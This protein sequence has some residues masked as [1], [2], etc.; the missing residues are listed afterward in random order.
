MKYEYVLNQGLTYN[1]YAFLKNSKK[2][3]KRLNLKSSPNTDS[4]IIYY[5]LSL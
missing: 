1:F 3:K 4:F 2:T 5:P